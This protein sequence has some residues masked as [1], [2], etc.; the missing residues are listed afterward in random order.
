MCGLVISKEETKQ[1]DHNCF[2]SLTQYLKRLIDEKDAAIALLKD[3]CTRKN[4]VIKQLMDNQT[5][6]EVR[7]TKI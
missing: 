4:R 6:L 7:L 3:E 2:Y 1:N 5:I